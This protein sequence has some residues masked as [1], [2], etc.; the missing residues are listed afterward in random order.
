LDKLAARAVDQHARAEKLR[1]AV[2]RTALGRAEN[3]EEA[4]ELPFVQEAK[5]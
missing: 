3:D 2:A 1:L 5:S 4:Q